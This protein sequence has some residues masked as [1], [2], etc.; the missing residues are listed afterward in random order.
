[1]FTG[2]IILSD[3]MLVLNF[4]TYIADISFIKTHYFSTESAT[5]GWYDW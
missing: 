3:D 4:I 2:I 5:S 1:M